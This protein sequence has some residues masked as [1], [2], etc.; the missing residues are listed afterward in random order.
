MEQFLKD[1][2]GIQLLCDHY[3]GLS[4]DRPGGGI[5]VHVDFHQVLLEAMTESKHVCD[6]NYGIVP[7]VHFISNHDQDNNAATTTT[8][9]TVVRPWVHHALVELF[10]NGMASS[11]QKMTMTM[12]TD[13]HLHNPPDLL[14]RMR[15]HPEK[16]TML[17][18][19]II[20]Q[21]VG[22]KDEEEIQRAFQFATSSTGQRWDRL[23][24]QQSY[25]MVRSPISSLGVGLPL[26]R[27]MMQRFGGDVILKRRSEPIQIDSFTVDTGCTAYLYV[28]LRDDIEEV[29]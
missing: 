7:H 15:Y 25:G 19:E 10:K 27:M 9:V 12:T 4:K 29:L 6:A 8:K 14:V 24:E 11:V 23:K 13:N 3:V 21:G 16:Q 20:D 18:C 22:F 5:S 26:S 17:V 28:P 2:L 1:R